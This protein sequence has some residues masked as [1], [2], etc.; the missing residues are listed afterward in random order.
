MLAIVSLVSLK[1]KALDS[2]IRQ[3]NEK[4]PGGGG[5]RL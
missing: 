1:L 5:T 4:W 3:E 2:V